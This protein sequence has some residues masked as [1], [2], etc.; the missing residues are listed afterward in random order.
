MRK[1]L[2]IAVLVLVCGCF[3]VAQDYPKAELFGGFS[4]VHADTEGTS[5]TSLDLPA[6]SSIKTWYPGWEISG[7]YNLTKM[8]G[9]KADF[10]GNYGQPVSVPAADIPAGSTALP[11]ARGYTFLFGPVVSFRGDR[12]T[13]FVHALFGGNHISTDAFDIVEVTGA[14]PAGSETAFAMAFGGGVDVKLTRH[15]SA[16]LGQFDYLYTKHCGNLFGTGCTLGLAGESEA[17]HQ[18]NFRFSTGIVIH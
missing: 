1:V 8:F 12:I 16:R 7:Q 9:V 18:N 4:M 11:H 10:A 15:F 17:A 14:V 2:F 13:P 3:A 5:V 6:G